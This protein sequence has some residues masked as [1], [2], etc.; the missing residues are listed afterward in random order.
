MKS[1]FLVLCSLLPA[2]LAQAQST[3]ARRLLERIIF[4]GSE[5]VE[6][7]LAPS[8]SV[9]RAV[10]LL[11]IMQATQ[12]GGS[13]QV[14]YI[15]RPALAT[16]FYVKQFR[17]RIEQSNEAGVDTTVNESRLMQV[18]PRLSERLECFID[19]VAS[20]SLPVYS[21]HLGVGSGKAPQASERRQLAR[22][23][24]RARR[25][26]YTVNLRQAPPYSRPYRAQLDPVG[27]ADADLIRQLGH[28]PARYY[29]RQRWAYHRA[30]RLVRDFIP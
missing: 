8:D 16:G 11:R 23:A 12:R 26:S 20:Y 22:L 21:A 25:Y 13:Y 3:P 19:Q 29:Y 9:A 15:Y 5:G 4:Y 30:L 17:V 14:L 28:H 18:P 1:F 10:Q 6:A 24:A 2:A 27:Y 7:Q